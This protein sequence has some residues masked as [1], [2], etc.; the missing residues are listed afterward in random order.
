MKSIRG[1]LQSLGINTISAYEFRVAARDGNLEIVRSYI[2][3]FSDD[4]K[5]REAINAWNPVSKN[6]YVTSHSE[7]D[8]NPALVLAAQYGHYDVV[9]LLI[10]EGL[11]NVNLRGSLG[12][13]PLIAAIDHQHSNIAARLLYYTASAEGANRHNQTA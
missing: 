13:T 5:K 8:T 7:I 4:A 11:A 10:T 9:E 1:I 6:T 3:Q 2:N 12:Q